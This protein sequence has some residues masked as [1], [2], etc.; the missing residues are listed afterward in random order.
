[1]WPFTIVGIGDKHSDLA[2]ADL[3]RRVAA[4]SPDDGDVDD[5][6]SLASVAKRLDE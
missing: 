3:R 2:V 6:R 5:Q 4:I 1:V